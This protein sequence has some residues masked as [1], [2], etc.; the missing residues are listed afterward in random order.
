MDKPEAAVVPVGSMQ[1]RAVG[2]RRGIWKIRLL[3][4]GLEAVRVDAPESY[5]LGRNEVRKSIQLKRSPL[6]GTEILFL[7]FGQRVVA[8]TPNSGQLSAIRE[9]MGAPT[10]DQLLAAI[11]RT[12]RWTLPLGIL[13]VLTS[14]PLSGDTD[15]GVAP[16]PADITGIVL[17]SV[18]VVQNLVGKVWPSREIFL[19][20]SLWFAIAG[21]ELIRNMVLGMSLLWSPVLIID[22][23]LVRYHWE[24]YREFKELADEPSE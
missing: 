14:L 21:A 6:G 24:R 23:L 15:S 20:D 7:K 16:L 19:L 9:W 5:V 22:F 4:D 8:F 11:H 10:R 1:V 17:G 2:G 18:L 13:I 12:F 3:D